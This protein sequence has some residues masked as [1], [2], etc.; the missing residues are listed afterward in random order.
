MHFIMFYTRVCHITSKPCGSISLRTVSIVTQSTMIIIVYDGSL[1][2]TNSVISKYRTQ[3]ISFKGKT[4]K[5]ILNE[6]I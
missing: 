3:N 5:E 2:F 6:I 1:I 4:T